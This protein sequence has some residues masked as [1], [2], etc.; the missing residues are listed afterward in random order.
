M[1]DPDVGDD[2][3]HDGDSTEIEEGFDFPEIAN[4]RMS[5]LFMGRK[6][7][8]LKDKSVE[9][10]LKKNDLKLIKKLIETVVGYGDQLSHLKRKEER[11]NG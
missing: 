4:K 2:S 6:N 8:D 3:S 9:Q 10:L 7:A 1:K 5:K 11:V